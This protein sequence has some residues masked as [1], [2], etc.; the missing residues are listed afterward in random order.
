MK[1]KTLIIL[2]VFLSVGLFAQ[3][4][5]LIWYDSPDVAPPGYYSERR[6]TFNDWLEGSGEEF[7]KGHTGLG[8]IGLMDAGY[9][10]D[11][12]FI[13]LSETA[14]SYQQPALDFLFL[15][16]STLN[17]LVENT[18]NTRD[19]VENFMAFYNTP[20][21]D[22][23]KASLEFYRMVA[24]SAIFDMEGVLNHHGMQIDSNLNS[25][26]EHFEAVYQDTSDF[27]F[28]LMTEWDEKV[29]VFNREAF[30][31]VH[32][33]EYHLTE[34]SRLWVYSW[35]M[36]SADTA[37]A[38]IGI[39]SLILSLDHLFESMM[40]VSEAFQNPPLEELYIE[41]W[42]AYI[43]AEF[44][45]IFAYLLDDAV[46]HI[47]LSETDTLHF[48]PVAFLE[49]HAYGM[50]PLYMDFYS[51]EDPYTYE[52]GR[53][54]PG[55]LPAFIVRQMLPDL[56]LNAGED[57]DAHKNHLIQKHAEFKLR[58]DP[59]WPLVGDPYD[60]DAYAGLAF[61]DF[62]RLLKYV[63]EE[64]EALFGYLDSGRLDSFFVHY[65]WNRMDLSEKNDEIRENL[66]PYAYCDSTVVFTVLLKTPNA[67]EGFKIEKGDS[68][69]PMYFLPEN[70]R[71]L[72]DGLDMT[73]E[74][75]AGVNEGIDSL[76]TN[77]NKYMD[78]SLDPNYL[79]FSSAETPLDYI[80]A[81][82]ASN[83]DFMKMTDYG[84]DRIR[85]M[86]PMLETAF[87]D[88]AVSAESMQLYFDAG[89]I[90]TQELAPIM[91]EM[92]IES[93][94]MIFMAEIALDMNIMS[95]EMLHNMSEDMGDPETTTDMMGERVNLSAWFDNPPDNFLQVA[96]RYLTGEDPSLH[97][98]FP[99]RSVRIEPLPFNP[100]EFVLY[101]NYPN[102]FN[103]L[104]SIH[105]DIPAEGRIKVIVF[106]IN[107][108]M[109]AELFNEQGHAGYYELTWDGGSLSS[110][111][112]FTR[113]SWNGQTQVQKMTLL[114]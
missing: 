21:Y 22:S 110:G 65:D 37:S 92:G 35:D 15:L 18:E 82:E 8:L 70:A 112:Y 104:T 6:N 3:E 95:Q 43:V 96:K 13:G 77:L 99:D 89:L 103:P 79:D 88:M 49:N 25:V 101:G 81:L 32:E 28:L 97:G 76:R 58:L 73:E 38:K 40:L 71:M 102:P 72:L 16:D 69:I 61:I 107:G 100:K 56:I 31:R 85:K 19:I 62:I 47:P 78:I 108:K 66:E 54:F 7:S 94:M 109:V 9:A 33:I 91:D 48:R 34:F 75:I 86:G 36:I 80:L 11:S 55:G 63:Q 1:K 59:P 113:I 41:P 2:C 17:F 114:K 60:F 24:D 12:L 51:S 42:P 111:V 45:M 93:G 39:D 105:F 27:E 90:L 68:F 84:K 44:S 74:A 14:L 29:F 20:A 83:P 10:V 98:L 64:S 26:A 57:E 23:L 5:D 4:A 50:I 67:S 46:F 52:F 53:L 106:D 87:Y 30:D